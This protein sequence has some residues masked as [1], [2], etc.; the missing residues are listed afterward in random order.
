MNGVQRSIAI[1]V[2]SLGLATAAFA[3]P[4]LAGAS[5]GEGSHWTSFGWHG[6]KS[7]E[8]MAKR[9]AAL[10]DKLGLSPAQEAAWKTFTDKLQAARKLY[11]QHLA[12]QRTYG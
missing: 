2:A 6:A 11:E 9:E 8:R 7:T 12:L 10:H 3:A 1:A 5:T 4:D